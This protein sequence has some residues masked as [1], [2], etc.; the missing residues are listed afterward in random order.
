VKR[1]SIRL[2]V[3][4]LV[5]VTA[6]LVFTAVAQGYVRG[7][8]GQLPV[9]EGPVY[10]DGTVRV[11]RNGLRIQVAS[12]TRDNFGTPYVLV[13]NIGPLAVGPEIGRRT[14]R[15]K[16]RTIS[17]P[18]YGTRAF[19]GTFTLFFNQRLLPGTIVSIGF[20]GYD[21]FDATVR[22][23]RLHRDDDDDDDD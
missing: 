23:C 1:A 18:P 21:T 5:A 12:D 8:E 3:L 15:L 11:C 19:S 13:A 10:N 7:N 20:E 2:L 9:T 14:V 22:N 6:G 17:T 16:R 4:G